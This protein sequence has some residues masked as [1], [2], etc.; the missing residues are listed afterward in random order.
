MLIVKE[1]FEINQSVIGLYLGSFDPVHDA[2]VQIPV[3]IFSTYKFDKIIYVPTGLSPV[4]KKPHISNSDR[5]KML[6]N[7]L[8]QYKYL[9]ISDYELKLKTI[10]YSIN[11]IKYFKKEYPQDKLRLIIGE[12]N[13]MSFEKWHKY[14]D[15]IDLLNIIILIRD[16]A[17]SCDNMM[18]LQKFITDDINQ[19]NESNS[20][21]IHYFNGLKSNISS[22]MIRNKI[23]DNRPIEKYVLADNYKYILEKKLYK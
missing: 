1:Q 17:K 22:T 6:E 7:A 21:M 13:F 4:G 23:R 15:I 11:T 20:K 5:L 12:D 10:C 19:F 8:H 14:S 18:T 9:S 16:N 3:K 2:H